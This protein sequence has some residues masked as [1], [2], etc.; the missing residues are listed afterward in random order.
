MFPRIRIKALRSPDKVGA[1]QNRRG[2]SQ[3]IM[4]TEQVPAANFTTGHNRPFVGQPLEF[5][6]CVPS[7]I[8]ECV[9][10]YNS[11]RWMFFSQSNHLLDTFRKQPIIRAE[12]FAVLATFGDV[13]ERSIGTADNVNKLIIM[14]E[15]DA[16]VAFRKSAGNLGR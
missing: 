5:D 14:N 11:H 3:K 4:T 16:A 15:M 10:A 7:V 13:S 8:P 2:I 6:S 1:K 12:Y 9:R